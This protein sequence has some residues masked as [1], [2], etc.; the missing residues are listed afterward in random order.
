M[1]VAAGTFWNHFIHS[2]EPPPLGGVGP[3]SGTAPGGTSAVT[4]GYCAVMWQ[5]RHEVVFRSAGPF[6]RLFHPRCCGGSSLEAKMTPCF[7]AGLIFVSVGG[8]GLVAFTVFSGSLPH[9][10][11]TGT[12]FRNLLGLF[13]W[14]LYANVP[15]T[16]PVPSGPSA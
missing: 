2:F 5:P 14:P 1:E 13:T 8:D 6:S 10:T 15:N 7:R 11:P 4:A 9:M 3:P 12:R 16:Q